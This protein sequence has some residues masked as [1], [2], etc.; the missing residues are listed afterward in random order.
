MY[1]KFEYASTINCIL[2]HCGMLVNAEY[3]SVPYNRIIL[4]AH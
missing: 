4:D 2:Y 1:H 3:L